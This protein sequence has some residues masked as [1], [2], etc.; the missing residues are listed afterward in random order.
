MLRRLLRAALAVV[1][2]LLLVA[3][4][5]H[6]VQTD[7]TELAPAPP[8]SLRVST[9]NVHWISLRATEGPWSVA[10][11]DRRKGP[12]TQV[13]RDIAPDILA[14]QEA[15]SFPGSNRD[16]TNLTVRHL[17]ETLPELGLAA[18]GAPQMFPPTQPILYR[19]DRLRLR[20]QGWFFFSD[21]PDVIYSRTF[22]GGFPAFASWAAF[23]TTSGQNFRVVNVHTDFGSRSNR[24]LSADL[25]AARIA[26]W[27]AEGITVF[28]VGDLNALHGA[29]TLRTIAQT[30]VTFLPSSGATFHMNRGLHLFGAIDHI[31]ASDGAT[32]VGD[33]VI[34]RTRP[35][36]I[37]PSDHYPVYADFMLGQP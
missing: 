7:R 28:V 20:D 36:G 2:A 24:R 19:R 3:C 21:T 13:L 1:A 22:N 12:M 6:L 25:I 16:G 27:I 30:G 26:P 37:W 29:Y 15:E 14:L 4:G 23:E 35:D 11:W 33:P 18:S 34:V 17:L 31:G 9:F 8:G 5:V 32:A 10:G